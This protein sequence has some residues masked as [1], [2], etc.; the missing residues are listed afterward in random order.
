[1]C[2]ARSL[3]EPFDESF[4][5]GDALSLSMVPAISADRKS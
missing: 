2:S 5:D 3:I 4:A 1:M